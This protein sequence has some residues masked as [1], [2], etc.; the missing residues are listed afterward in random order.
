MDKGRDF[1]QRW[2]VRWGKRMACHAE[3]SAQ[4]LTFQGLNGDNSSGLYRVTHATV[5]MDKHDTLIASELII[6]MP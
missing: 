1:V 3:K 5:A 4:R 6:L 2:R